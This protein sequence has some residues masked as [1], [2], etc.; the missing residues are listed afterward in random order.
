MTQATKEFNFVRIDQMAYLI[1]GGN[2]Q[3]RK[4]KI[5]FIC[6]QLGID[7]SDNQP[8]QLIIRPEN[9][10]GIDQIRDIKRFLNQK[11]WQGGQTK[12][13]IIFEADQMT[14]EAQ[15]AL[16]KTLEEPP[17]NSELILA[18]KNKTGLLPTIISR[19]QLVYLPT[20]RQST[21]KEDQTDWEKIEKMTI[22]DRMEYFQSIPQT[23]S[24]LEDWLN[25]KIRVLQE[26][27]SADQTKSQTIAKRIKLLDQARVMLGNN[28]TPIRILDWLAMKLPQA[29]MPG[30]I[31]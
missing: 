31:L 14:N 18:A 23:S 10:I 9:S 1:V 12:V 16:L 27:L 19:S 17:A 20:A 29:R 24:G 28:L 11:S 7:L 26:N 25:D 22:G 8:D 13:A 15:N 2:H 6:Q 4:D 3:S 30:G 21:K 5:L